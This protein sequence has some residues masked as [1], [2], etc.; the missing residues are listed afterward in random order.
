MKKTW[1]AAGGLLILAGA[2][3]AVVA[4]KSTGQPATAKAAWGSGE[5]TCRMQAREKVITGAHKV[6]GLKD[7][8]YG[9]WLAKTVFRNDTGAVVKDLKVRYK[10]GEWAE[11]C[12]W[13]AYPELAP[14]Q[15]VVDLYFPIISG[16]VAQLTSRTPAELLMEYEYTTPWGQKRTGQK[17]ERLSLLG[18]REFYFTDLRQE[19]QSGS[20]QDKDTYGPLLAAWV[21]SADGPVSRLASLANK[22]AGGAAACLKEEDCLAAMKECY[23]VMRDIKITYQTPAFQ[24]EP[25]KSYDLMLVQSLQY[26]R[27]TIEKRSGTCIDLAIL[28]ASMLNSLG[29]KP[30]LVSKDEHCFPMGLTPGGRQVP[31][32]ATG[33]RGGGN[34]DDFA[35]AR[36]N[37]EKTWQEIQKNGRFRLIDCQ[38]C[39]AAGI[40]PAEL[41]T[42]PADI[43]ERW[44][45]TD[46]VLSPPRTAGG[47]A[48]PPGGTPGLT[49][50]VPTPPTPP[51]P[52]VQPA[53]MAPGPWSC[54]VAA[55]QGNTTQVAV[56][57]AVQANRVQMVCLAQY[58]LVGPDGLTHHAREQSTFL[59]TVGGAVVEAQCVQ[60]VWTIDGQPVPPQHLPLLLRLTLSPDGRS[61]QGTV[62]NSAGATGQVTMRA[63]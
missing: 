52:P 4:I 38:E 58:P 24:A 14:T 54:Q 44:K 12:T 42:L 19:E 49:P 60:A 36:Q 18:R 29:I 45:I 55:P 39:W 59:G 26:P 28:Y 40:S 22:R 17:S 47:G 16:K 35:A 34:S 10:L 3:L 1:R 15:T 11:W 2:A 32:E 48:C 50:P 57:V 13:Q 51:V 62:T 25:G 6:Y 56:Q 53:P 30:Y 46:V 9:L 7:S 20:F 61:A 23:E 31:V 27:D 8:P 37:A 5:L 21:T 33:V 43:L 63:Q 41:E